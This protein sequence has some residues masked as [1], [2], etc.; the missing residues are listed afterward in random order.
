MCIRDRNGIV[1]VVNGLLDWI[2]G[3]GPK[4]IDPVFNIAQEEFKIAES[5]RMRDERQARELA[6]KTK[7][8]A[9]S[10]KDV[11][12]G[13][14]GAGAGGVAGSE[15]NAQSAMA[16]LNSNQFNITTFAPNNINAPTST[17]ISNQTNLTPSASR[18]RTP[19]NRSMARRSYS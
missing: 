18:L 8:T 7:E 3:F 15:V 13:A 10:A 2:P 14:V 9:N 1:T 11:V 17:N 19:L 4:T 6:E 16:A 5:N 12:E